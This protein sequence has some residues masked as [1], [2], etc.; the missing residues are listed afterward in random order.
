M[1]QI[2][3]LAIR[4]DPVQE[5]T[6]SQASTDSL[7]ISPPVRQTASEKSTFEQGLLNLQSYSK[8]IFANVAP[9]K[10]KDEDLDIPTFQRR[11]IS[12]DKGSTGK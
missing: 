12:I 9:A 4:Y 10:Y 3:A 7:W 1:V 5:T 2:A 6:V 11:G 8:G